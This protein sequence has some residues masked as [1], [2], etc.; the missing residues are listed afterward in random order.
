[1]LYLQLRWA[2]K[3]GQRAL[4]ELPKSSQRA[5][6]EPQKALEELPESLLTK[7]GKKLLKICLQ[8]SFVA[9]TSS[10][11]SPKKH[12]T[13]SPTATVHSKVP[14]TALNIEIFQFGIDSLILHT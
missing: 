1:M 7:L 5:P 14:Y 8:K 9:P 13:M 12:S 4:K 3:K 2:P 10:P 6:K 11:Q